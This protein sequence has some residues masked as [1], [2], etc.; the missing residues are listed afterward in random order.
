VIPELVVAAVLSAAPTTLDGVPVHL[1]PGTEQVVTVNHGDGYRARVSFWKLTDAG[2][3]AG[4]E[5]EDG[6]I[7]YGGLVRGTHREQGSGATPLGTYLLP[8]AFGMDAGNQ[9]WKLRYRQV[10]TGDFWVQDNESDHYNRYRNQAVGGFRWWLPSSDPDSSE[11]LT[12][13]RHQY[14]ISIVTDFNHRQVRHRGAGIFLHVNGPGP[15][16]GCVSAPGRFLDKLMRVLD[17]DRVPVIAVG[18]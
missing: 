9:E 2:W 6:R 3:Q 4:F 7:G 14:R 5:T 16:S 8:W 11:R 17:P 15:T 18:R 13:F 10:R 1:R 12:D